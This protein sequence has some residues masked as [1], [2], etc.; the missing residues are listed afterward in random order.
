MTDDQFGESQFGKKIRQCAQS[1][2]W[3]DSQINFMH[4]IE[5]GY[6]NDHE[7]RLYVTL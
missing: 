6:L 1:S 2:N 7:I 3:R 5:C 4:R